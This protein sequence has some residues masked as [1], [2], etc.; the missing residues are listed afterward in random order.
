MDT[1]NFL[2]RIWAIKLIPKKR[3]KELL[4]ITPPMEVYY[5]EIPGENFFILCSKRFID[6]WEKNE[7]GS[8]S[9]EE[10]DEFWDVYSEDTEFLGD[11]IL[12]CSD[13]KSISIN[14]DLYKLSNLTEILSF[15]SS[16]GFTTIYYDKLS[17]FYE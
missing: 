6:I 2:W 9:D 14:E 8:L 12:S 16:L 5:R 11:L 15:L 1:L 17:E 4:K 10:Y 13:V 7:E 3:G